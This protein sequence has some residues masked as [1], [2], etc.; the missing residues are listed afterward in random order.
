MSFVT[1][2]NIPLIAHA[3]EPSQQLAFPG[4]KGFGK[5]SQGGKGGEVY[6]VTSLLDELENPSKGTLRYAIKSKNPRTIVFNVSGVIHLKSPLKIKYGNVTIAGQTSPGGITL[7]GAPVSINK[8]N[9][10]IIRHLRFRLGTSGYAEDSFSVRDSEDIIID[11][12]SLSWSV[13]ETASFYNNR[14]FTLQN[15][16]ISH[17][18]S[19]SIHPKGDHGYG[20][21]W[22]GANA[23]FINNVI[24]NHTSRTPRINGYRLKPTYKLEE[25]FVE[26][27]NNT[28]FNWGHNNIYGSE[29]GRFN[30]INNYFK[31]GKASKIIQ[32]VD[33]WYSPL[34]KEN[35]AYISGNFYQ[36]N[37]EITAQNW[38]GVNVRDAVKSKRIKLP[39]DHVL[40]SQ[41]PII[42]A[43]NAS[44]EQHFLDAK[45]N[46]NQVIS[47]RN[48][49]ANRNANGI[50]IDSVDSLVYQQLTDEVEIVKNGIIDH[51]FE[52]IGSWACF[53]KQFLSFPAINDDN[54]DGVNDAWA[55]NKLMASE[56]KTMSS[57]DLLFKYINELAQ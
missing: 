12:C 39:K 47:Q 43:N 31:S 15:S 9:N 13:D 36:Y 44:T 26:I 30:L 25:E 54:N 3:D 14:A 20:G 21:I 33:I 52:L 4:A 45:S 29:N 1:T 53:E 18:L 16:I 57:E 27:I 7:T 10:I 56:Y 41:T 42:P 5:Y 51:E 23:S 35:Q 55:K 49:G 22:G 40:F 11:H 19:K 6:I 24:A 2:A 17:S 46:F 50:F 34:I 48:V 37:D 8:S 32:L 28:I 38:L